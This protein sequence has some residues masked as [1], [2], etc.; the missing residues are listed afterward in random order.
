MSSDVIQVSMHAASLKFGSKPDPTIAIQSVA[1]GFPLTYAQDRALHAIQQLFDDTEYKGNEPPVKPTHGRKYHFNETLP[2]L[3]VKTA[4]YLV[5]YGVTKLKNIFSPGARRLAVNGLKDL[6]YTK[7][8]ITYKKTVKRK[9]FKK[10]MVQDIAPLLALTWSPTGRNVTI[11]PNPVL[12][13]QRKGYYMLKPA[14]FFDLV[15][16]KDPVKVRFLEYLLFQLEGKRRKGRRK[17]KM[18]PEIRISTENL[19][20]SLHLERL[21]VQRKPTELRTKLNE[22]YEFA[23][24]VGY[25]DSYAIDQPGSRN[26]VVDVLQLKV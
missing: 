13:D 20:W 9:T 26:K 21:I 22:L 19:A 5:A 12:V 23:Q 4:D 7:Y 10:V 3:K 8:S 1:K 2:V 25:L 17:G 6:A 24:G 11:I 14:D 15:P 16:D 18:D